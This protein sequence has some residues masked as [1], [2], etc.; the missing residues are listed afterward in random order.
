M[1]VPLKKHWVKMDAWRGY[2]QY[3]NS[4]LDGSFLWGDNLHNQSE[5]NRIKKAREILKNAKIPFRVKGTPTSNVFS[6]GYDV[7]VEPRNV[8]K[9]KRLLKKVM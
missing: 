1:N 7:V 5:M 8:N 6:S 9:A 2:Y 3:D 4:V